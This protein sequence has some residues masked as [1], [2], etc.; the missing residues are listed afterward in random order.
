MTSKAKL[1]EIWAAIEYKRLETNMGLFEWKQ[2][3][4]GVSEAIKQKKCI[5]E[6]TKEEFDAIEIPKDRNNAS[7]Y[8]W[9]K[10]IV[11]RDGIKHDLI[12]I[13]SILNGTSSL[14][15][16]E[17][18]ELVNQE[19]SKKISL[20]QPKGQVVNNNMEYDSIIKLIKILN[21]S[22]GKIFDFV[23][24]LEG[25]LSDFAYRNINNNELES[26]VSVQIKSSSIRNNN[27][28]QFHINVKEIIKILENGIALM[29]IGI[30]K[31]K[32]IS[33][34]WFFFGEKTL[35]TFKQFENTNQYF[36]LNQLILEQMNVEFKIKLRVII[37]FMLEIM[38]DILII[39]IILMYFKFQ[40]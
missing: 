37:N 19:I 10:I 23:H 36:H 9:R 31:D 35:I 15:T 12:S 2:S 38:V 22:V 27:R 28:F 29:C 14:K 20:L 32:N 5:I 18:K 30:N 39:L 25:R 21:E 26:F 13:E 6:M 8:G 7:H 3:Y 40:I 11:S 24:L 1:S 33:V 17:E 16:K 34:V 4:E